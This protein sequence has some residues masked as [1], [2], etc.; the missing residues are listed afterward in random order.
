M[1]CPLSCEGN[2]EC[3][4]SNVDAPFKDHFKGTCVAV[5][6]TAPKECELTCP[7]YTWCETANQR[8]GMCLD[9]R[10]YEQCDKTTEESCLNDT[11]YDLLFPC[12]WDGTRPEGQRCFIDEEP[13]KGSPKLGQPCTAYDG[14]IGECQRLIVPSSEANNNLTLVEKGPWFCKTCTQVNQAARWR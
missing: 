7:T 11:K 10:C 8:R 5:A 13:C 6:G 3:T 4:G 2:A 12:R 14:A 9:G 1:I